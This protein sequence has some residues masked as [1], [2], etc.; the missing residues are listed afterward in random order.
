MK[1]KKY[2]IKNSTYIPEEWGK[3]MPTGWV[4]PLCGRVL[5][6]WTNY[7]LCRTPQ[8]VTCPDSEPIVNP[9]IT[10]NS[11]TTG[12]SQR[13]TC[14]AWMTTYPPIEGQPIKMEY[15]DIKGAFIG[16]TELDFFINGSDAYD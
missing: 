3:L 9:S 2:K 15:P 8:P 16:N 4:C 10:W 6:P 7:C 11:P 1:Q 5:S 12:R 14:T 13:K